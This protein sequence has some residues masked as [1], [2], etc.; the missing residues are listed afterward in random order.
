MRVRRVVLLVAAIAAPVF[1]QTD[2]NGLTVTANRPLSVQPDQQVLQ[3]NVSSTLNAGLDDVLAA[4]AS[5]GIKAT[6][7]SG[8]SGPTTQYSS[9]NAQTQVLHWSFRFPVPLATVK[10]T[11]AALDSLMQTI[12]GKNSGWSLQFYGTGL[13]VSQEALAT[14]QCSIPALIA[15]ARAQAQKTAAATGVALGPIVAISDGQSAPAATP[16]VVW[17]GVVSG[18]IFSG[19]IF[20]S[21]APSPPPA[22]SVVV[23]FSL[24][25]NQ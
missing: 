9:G 24:L 3:V 13:Q 22:C 8:V 12:G 19:L 5:A 17:G 2:T 7:L 15:D 18:E 23:K 10:S 6:D 20:L 1:A 25:P 11:I 16:V 14:Q 21:P 4:I